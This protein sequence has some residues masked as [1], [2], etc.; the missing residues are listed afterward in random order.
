MTSLKG[1]AGVT[2]CTV[3]LGIAFAEMGKKVLIL[4]GD[5]E[6]A[7]SLVAADCANRQVYTLGDY[8]RGSCRAKQTIVC[9][10][11][12]VNLSLMSSVGLSDESY[13]ERAIDEVEGLYD[14]VISDKLAPKKFDTAIV[15][16]EPFV[17]SI[18]CADKTRANLQDSGYKSIFL[19]VNKLC[20]GQ[21]VEGKIITAEEIA[22]ILRLSLLGVIPEDL[23]APL[24][25][26]SKGTK[27]AFSLAA[28]RLE[29]KDC[30]VYNVVKP[31]FGLHGYV[32]RKAR[33]I[34]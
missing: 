31:Y 29:G 7:S 11:N 34:V 8:Q 30:G 17:L 33:K 14:V 22:S 27:K 24:G 10:K 20:G 25:A 12:Y 1:G 18:K 26:I 19:I 13:A 23:T 32:K 6:C 2:F 3:N 28:Q 9:H 5:R 21:I 16:T 4:D 15:V